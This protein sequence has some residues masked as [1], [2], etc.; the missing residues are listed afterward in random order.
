[1]TAEKTSSR[2]KPAD[3]CIGQDCSEGLLAE[4]AYTD[5]H[6]ISAC[7]DKAESFEGLHHRESGAFL[8][9]DN[10]AHL[11][12]ILVSRENH[13]M[14][15]KLLR[16]GIS[17]IRGVSVKRKGHEKVNRASFKTS[18]VQPANRSFVGEKVQ[19]PRYAYGNQGESYA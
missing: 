15:K 17:H 7:L 10:P 13:E 12:R 16:L 6:T 3:I 14:R 19:E 8:V 2:V 18:V 4:A 9:Q 5:H 11:K 1:M